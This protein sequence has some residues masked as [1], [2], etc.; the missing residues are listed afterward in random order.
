MLDAVFGNDEKAV[1]ESDCKNYLEGRLKS[2]QQ[3]LDEEEK[4][5][6][7]TS[8]PLQLCYC[9]EN[10]N[11]I[12]KKTTLTSGGFNFRRNLLALL[13]NQNLCV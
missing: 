3:L 4:R 5:L 12:L 7:S 10:I 9:A 13:V 11:V 1:L 6:T 8:S 2:V